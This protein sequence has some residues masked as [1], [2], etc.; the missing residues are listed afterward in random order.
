MDGG[1]TPWRPRHPACR[2][3]SEPQRPPRSAASAGRFRPSS[4]R[5]RPRCRTRRPRPRS[6]EHTSELQSPYDL[7]CRLLLEKKK[8]KADGDQTLVHVSET[9][10]TTE[11]DNA[12]RCHLDGIEP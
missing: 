5:T 12:C 10:T 9:D 11:R 8:K 3:S 1:W 4:P 2:S 7:V 6:E